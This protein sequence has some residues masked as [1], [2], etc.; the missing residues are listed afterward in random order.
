MFNHTAKLQCPMSSIP[1][2]LQTYLKEQELISVQ[3]PPELPKRTD[4]F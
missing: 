2:S 4:A 1:F 3:G